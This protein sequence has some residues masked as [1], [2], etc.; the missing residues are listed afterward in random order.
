M[1]HIKLA[2][3]CKNQPHHSRKDIMMRRRITTN[4][5]AISPYT[6]NL[7]RPSVSQ[8]KHEHLQSMAQPK[9]SGSRPPAVNQTIHPIECCR[10][11]V[12]F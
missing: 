12:F 7:T 9:H 11:D 5:A 10:D 3:P 6:H 2:Q 1:K 8:N 4:P